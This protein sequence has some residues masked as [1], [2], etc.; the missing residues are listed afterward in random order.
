MKQFFALLAVFTLFSGMA[1][2][3]S[4][5]TF[6]FPSATTW[7]S[8][9]GGSDFFGN[10][11]GLSYP[12]YTQGDYISETFVTGPTWVSSLSLDWSLINDF[13][14]NPGN[15]YENYIY[16][17]GLFVAS[18]SVDDCGFCINQESIGGAVTFNPIYGY[19]TYNI[20]VVLAQSAPSGGGYEQFADVTVA[21]GPATVELVGSPEPASMLLFA[22]GLIGAAGMARRRLSR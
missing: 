6:N 2:A 22:S 17:N 12:M 7:S 4:T 21:G 11:G 14:G 20:S 8:T 10:N 3:G 5:Y 18:F 15:S 16:L 9:A 13:G 19:G 1:F